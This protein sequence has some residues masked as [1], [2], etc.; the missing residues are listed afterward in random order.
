MQIARQEKLHHIAIHSSN[1]DATPDLNMDSS[2]F[3]L[4]RWITSNWK[5]TQAASSGLRK[6]YKSKHNV[7]REKPP[8]EQNH[9]K[10]NS[11]E[12]P[13]TG[14]PQFETRLAPTVYPKLGMDVCM[15]KQNETPSHLFKTFRHLSK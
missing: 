2:H 13:N 5:P 8:P 11:W 14:V 3:A 15:L 7:S 4:E 10:P 1:I 9:V 6:M 12:N